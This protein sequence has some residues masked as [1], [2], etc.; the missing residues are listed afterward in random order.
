MSRYNIP[1]ILKFNEDM[2]TTTHNKTFR[3]AM[4]DALLLKVILLACAMCNKHCT[5][6]L[7]LV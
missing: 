1:Y 3:S 6:L 5:L 2:I 7:N 4:V